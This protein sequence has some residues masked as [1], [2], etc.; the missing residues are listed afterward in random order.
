[1]TEGT[2]GAIPNTLSPTNLLISLLLSPQLDVTRTIGRG[3]K[4]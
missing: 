3:L 1:M 4:A 2:Q